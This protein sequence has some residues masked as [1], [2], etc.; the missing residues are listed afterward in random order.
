MKAAND[1]GLRVFMRHRAGEAED[2]FTADMSVGL[3]IHGIVTGPPC[4]DGSSG[5]GDGG[6]D[7]GGG[8]EG[9]ETG[10]TG[11]TGETGEER[12]DGGGR[13]CA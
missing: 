8:G 2:T 4:A 1:A 5:G 6:G 9:N 12:V 10:E 13:L 3:D 7:G 11:K